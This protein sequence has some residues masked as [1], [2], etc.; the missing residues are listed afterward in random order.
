MIAPMKAI[1]ALRAFAVLVSSGCAATSQSEGSATARLLAA[2]GF[3]VRRD[4]PEGL[5]HLKELPAR[6]QL[7]VRPTK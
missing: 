5:A 1:T 6:R 2:A 7:S 4:T 3:Q